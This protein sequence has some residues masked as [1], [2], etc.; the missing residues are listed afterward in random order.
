[1]IV[2]FVS[3]FGVS[4]IYTYDNA[5]ISYSV[6]PLDKFPKSTE[7]EKNTGV[8]VVPIVTTVPSV[9]LEYNNL[10]SKF[11]A[12]SPTSKSPEVGAP[13]TSLLLGLITVGILYFL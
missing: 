12:I 2:P 11:I 6:A 8:S 13:L 10:S 4:F 5:P 9:F 1:L 7:S 3:S